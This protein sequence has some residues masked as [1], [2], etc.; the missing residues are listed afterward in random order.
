MVS[1][2]SWHAF[3]SIHEDRDSG[4][5]SL[6]KL[7][8]DSGMESSGDAVFLHHHLLEPRK[9]TQETALL[10]GEGK[11]NS[12]SLFTQRCLVASVCLVSLMELHCVQT[13]DW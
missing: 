3:C 7:A 5:P 12:I 9:A 2:S 11:V 4:L 1:G 8:L 6:L 10:H 13:Q